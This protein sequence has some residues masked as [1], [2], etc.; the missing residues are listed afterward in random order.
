MC[1]TAFRILRPRYSVATSH[2]AG[3]GFTTEYQGPTNPVRT[4]LAPVA[5]NG[6]SVCRALYF[7]FLMYS[8]ATSDLSAPSPRR[9]GGQTTRANP[10]AGFVSSVFWGELGPF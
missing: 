5:D 6:G 7:S 1:P 4:I 3:G 9:G 2:K 10:P 8:S